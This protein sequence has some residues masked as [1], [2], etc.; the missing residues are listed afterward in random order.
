M[1]KA[2]KLIIILILMDFISFAQDTNCV[3]IAGKATFHFNYYIG[4][5]DS[6][7][8]DEK[9]QDKEFGILPNEV[10]VVDLYD[11]HSKVKSVKIKQRK[12]KVYY[13]DNTTQSFWTRSGDESF[14]FYGESIERIVI[15]KPI[16]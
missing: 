16:F 4:E 10:L 11:N 12:I 8:V 7:V 15:N 14:E 13:T 1:K 9:L 6:V 5:I 2:I 3:L